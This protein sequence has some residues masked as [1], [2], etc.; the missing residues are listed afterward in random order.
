MVI[1][2][3]A[4]PNKMTAFFLKRYI[5][6]K[7]V[8]QLIVISEALKKLTIEKLGPVGDVINVLHDGADVY[9]NDPEDTNEVKHIISVAYAGHLYKGRGIEVIIALAN[10]FDAVQ[11]DIYGGEEKDV[12]FYKNLC[13]KLTNI[14]FHGFVKPGE[15]NERLAKADILVAPYQKKVF[16]KNGMNTSD[17]MSP[18]KIFEYMSLGKAIL[19]SKLPVLEEVLTHNQNALLCESDELKDWISN[20]TNLLTDQNLMLK[21]SQNAKTDLELKY[22]WES[23]SKSILSFSPQK[24]TS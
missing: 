14:T 12:V 1:E 21:I 22:S 20:L 11:F 8:N 16:L 17:Y 15:V 13:E 3:H 18:L 4:P 9:K 10:H 24:A 23:R 5:R 7:K 19:C 6:R 2:L